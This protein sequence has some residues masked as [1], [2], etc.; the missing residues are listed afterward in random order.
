MLTEQLGFS[1]GD[2][3]SEKY[4][5]KLI[6]EKTLTQDVTN[7]KLEELK[8]VN[9]KVAMAL[10]EIKKLDDT[11]LIEK[12]LKVFEVTNEEGEIAY[13]TRV[14]IRITHTDSINDLVVV[15]EIPKDV[16]MY[17]SD[18]E[19]LDLTEVLEED[20]IVKWNFDHV[21]KDQAKEFGYSVDKKLDT[22]DSTTI[23]G[24]NEPSAVAKWIRNLFAKW[25]N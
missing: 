7:D 18:I 11:P 4:T 16:A 3:D 20:P 13:V 8:D 5:V 19:F 10:K 15:E 17:A 12:E 1:S 25:F 9:D 14:I 24:G 2:I 23:A 22:V 21:P 6:E